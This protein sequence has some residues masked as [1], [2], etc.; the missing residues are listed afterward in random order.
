MPTGRTLSTNGDISQRTNLYAAGQMLSY[1]G[2]HIVLDKFGMSKPMPRNKSTTIKFRRPKVFTAADTPLQEGVT[3]SATQFGYEDVP[4]TLKQYGMV[5]EITDVIQ[6]THEDPVLQDATE[7]CG[8]NI[9]RTV[10]ALTYGVLKGGT[11]VFYANG[12]ARNAVNTPISLNKLRSVTRALKAQK[13]KKITRILDGSVMYRTSPVEASYVVC[14]HTDVEQDIRNLAG[15]IPVAEYGQ[16][17]TVHEMEFGTV[18]D[19][20]F[21]CSA[22]LDPIID[23]GGAFGGSGTSMVTTSGT[24]ADVYPLLCFGKEAYGLVP[25]RGYNAVEPSIINPNVKTKDD[26]LG[27]RGYVGWKTWFVAVILN[28]SWMARLEVAVSQL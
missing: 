1:A 18:E 17:R 27:Q 21:V 8:D 26:P 28:E 12:T 3:P 10:E 2:P 20:R 5:V 19:F 11:N 13:A 15:F 16:R 22:D 23:A 24:S 6:D 9:G 14:H 25:L 7:Q 4:A